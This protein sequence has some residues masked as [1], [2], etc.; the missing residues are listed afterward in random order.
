LRH[1]REKS[2]VGT[3]TGVEEESRRGAEGLSEAGFERSMDMV[4]D[5]GPGAA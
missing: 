3:K 1:A 5:E 4:I 2:P